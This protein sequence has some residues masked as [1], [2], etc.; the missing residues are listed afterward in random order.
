MAKNCDVSSP[1]AVPTMPNKYINA[2]YFSSFC[3]LNIWLPL[4][5]DILTSKMPNTI[6]DQHFEEEIF[7]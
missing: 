5:R 7:S 1:F 2:F 4:N 6:L 3:Q